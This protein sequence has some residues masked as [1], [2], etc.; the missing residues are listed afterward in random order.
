M[1]I[2]VVEDEIRLAEAISQILKTNKYDVDVFHDGQS[3][4]DYALTDIYDL[5]VLDIMLPK[6]NG[7]EILKHCR[8]NKIHTPILLL[9]AKDE[10]SDKVRGL[11]LGADDYLTKP[12][13]TE[14]LLARIRALLRRHGKVTNDSL[15]FHDAELNLLTYELSCGVKSIK[16]GLKEFNILRYLFSHGN[17]VVTKELLIEKVWGFE[18]DIEYNNVE[19]Y[20]SFLR[21]K[22]S[23]VRS[24][25]MIRTVRGVGYCLGVSEN[26]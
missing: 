16:L 13:A 5:I 1:R 14:E 22:L 3:G 2:L 23:F 12:F 20:I 17:Q 19:V 15:H 25:V 9:T 10:I 8:Q 24:T 4:L 18:A 26:D 6:L 21:K 11:D 7:F